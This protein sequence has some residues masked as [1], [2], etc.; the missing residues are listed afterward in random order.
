MAKEFIVD[1]ISMLKPLVGRLVD[2]EHEG[3]KVTARILKVDEEGAHLRVVPK[4][5]KD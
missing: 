4:E 3:K 1:H 5:T 2:T